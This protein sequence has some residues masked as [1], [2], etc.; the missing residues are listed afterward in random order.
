MLKR[1]SLNTPYEPFPLTTFIIHEPIK[2]SIPCNEKFIILSDHLRKNGG[3]AS[4]CFLQRVSGI[5]KNPLAN[6]PR[7]NP[8]IA[9]LRFTVAMVHRH[10]SIKYRTLATVWK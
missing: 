6:G 7:Q 3:K 9:H 2:G 5:F 10:T 1:T 8:P 4:E